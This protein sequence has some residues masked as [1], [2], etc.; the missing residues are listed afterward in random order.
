MTVDDLC[1]GW[2]N[3]IGGFCAKDS[4]IGANATQAERCMPGKSIFGAPTCW[5]LK[6]HAAGQNHNLFRFGMSSRPRYKFLNI[7]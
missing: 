1:G 3:L 5:L 4:L 6:I 7:F 2:I